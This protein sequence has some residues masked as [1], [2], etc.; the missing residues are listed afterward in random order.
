MS[1]DRTVAE[2]VFVALP[3]LLVVMVA[4]TGVTLCRCLGSPILICS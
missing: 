1:I 2:F 4:V 3:L